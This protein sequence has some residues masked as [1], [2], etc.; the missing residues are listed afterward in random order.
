MLV[1]DGVFVDA[2]CAFNNILSDVFKAAPEIK[3][4]L[5]RIELNMVGL[6]AYGLLI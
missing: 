1:A 5:K 6:L 3:N 2:I 4:V